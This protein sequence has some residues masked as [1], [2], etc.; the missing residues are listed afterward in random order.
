MD[1]VRNSSAATLIERG[2]GDGIVERV[3]KGVSPITDEPNIRAEGEAVIVF[4]P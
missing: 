2:I 3:I 4:H 1:P